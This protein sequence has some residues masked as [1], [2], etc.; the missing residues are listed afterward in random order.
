MTAEAQW[1]HRVCRGRSTTSCP[2]QLPTGSGH[3]AVRSP[4]QWSLCVWIRSECPLW[5]HSGLP[6]ASFGERVWSS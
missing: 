5:G 1:V 4:G 6:G 2:S 3:P